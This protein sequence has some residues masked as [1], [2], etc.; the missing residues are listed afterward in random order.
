MC[1]YLSLPLLALSLIILR[2]PNTSGYPNSLACNK[3]EATATGCFMLFHKTA[4][5]HKFS[6]MA[7]ETFDNTSRKL[8]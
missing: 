8:F 7:H 4:A 3:V 1:A 5:L 2:L 6:S